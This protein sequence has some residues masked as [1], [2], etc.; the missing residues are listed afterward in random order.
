MPNKDPFAGELAG[1]RAL[2]G[3]NV[4]RMV[5]IELVLDK[6]WWQGEIFPESWLPAATIFAD[7][8][9]FPF[10]KE[11]TVEVLAPEMILSVDE[12]ET[13]T[14]VSGERLVN[15]LLK[16]PFHALELPYSFNFS[17]RAV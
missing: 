1:F 10:L 17:V 2:S 14:F 9:S 13:H 8:G 15:G 6:M 11:F 12:Y 4:L 3:M 16:V 5:Y 7:P